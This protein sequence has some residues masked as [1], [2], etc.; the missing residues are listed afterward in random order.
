MDNIKSPSVSSFDQMLTGKL[1]G[2]QISQTSGGPGG[3]VNVVLR[4]VSSITGGNEPLYVIDGFPI[5]GGASSDL[6]HMG[7]G[8]TLQV[9]LQVIH[10]LEL[11]L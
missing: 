11:I 7:L 8:C 9:V 10:C 3:N 5:T 4:G 6:T 2:L 1:A